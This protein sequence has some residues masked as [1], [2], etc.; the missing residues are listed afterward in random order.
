MRPIA[1]LS[2]ATLF[3]LGALVSTSAS[4]WD[5]YRY[6]QRTTTIQEIDDDDRPPPRYGHGYRSIGYGDGYE[7][8]RYRTRRIT[9]EVIEYDRDDDIDD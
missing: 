2:A 8:P 1:L 4:A 9:R 5:G 7:A 3:G 6:S